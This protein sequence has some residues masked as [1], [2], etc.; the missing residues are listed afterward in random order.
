MTPAGKRRHRLLVALAVV[1]VLAW[2][3]PVLWLINVALK[4][5][6]QL[7]VPKPTFIFTPTLQN[8]LQSLLQNLQTQ[9]NGAQSAGLLINASA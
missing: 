3:V 7:F 8:F 1:V 9:G 2:L 4:T 6:A 5:Q